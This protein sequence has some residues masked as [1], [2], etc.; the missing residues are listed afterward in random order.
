MWTWEALSELHW[1]LCNGKGSHL[2]LRQEPKGSSPFKTPT[3]GSL[4]SWD[5]RVRPRLVWRLLAMDKT[6][7]KGST[8]VTKEPLTPK[9]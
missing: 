2:E 3:T 8:T 7:T 6:F 4:K 9:V 5:R 1:V